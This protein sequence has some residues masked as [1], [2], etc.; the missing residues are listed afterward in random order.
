MDDSRVTIYCDEIIISDAILQRVNLEMTL[1]RKNQ[2]PTP[3]LSISDSLH[4]L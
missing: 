4:P 3:P 1:I 2:P